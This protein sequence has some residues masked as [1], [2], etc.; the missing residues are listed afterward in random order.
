MLVKN[1]LS[2]TAGSTTL[3]LQT[4]NYDFFLFSVNFYEKQ[5]RKDFR[6]LFIS[7]TVSWNTEHVHYKSD[8]CI[9][10]IAT[11][12]LKYYS[13]FSLK[14][15]LKKSKQFFFQERSN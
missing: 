2:Y 3:P 13:L 6:M 11:L 4:R 7:I 1:H 5:N 12:I 10:Y 15:K 8:L 14:F 9:Y